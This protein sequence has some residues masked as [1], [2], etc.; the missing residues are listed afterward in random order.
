MQSDDNQVGKLALAMETAIL[1]ELATWEMI[2]LINGDRSSEVNRP[3]GQNVSLLYEM[4]E[5]ALWDT[6]K[7]NE[8]EAKLLEKIATGNAMV[9][10]VA[11]LDKE[12]IPKLTADLASD[13]SIQTPKYNN[14]WEHKSIRLCIEAIRDFNCDSDESPLAGTGEVHCRIADYLS[15][16]WLNGSSLEWLLLDA[17]IYTTLWDTLNKARDIDYDYCD[18]RYGQYLIERLAACS[19]SRYEPFLGANLSD[20]CADGARKQPSRIW[21]CFVVDE[22]SKSV[23][24]ICLPLAAAAG[25]Y[26]GGKYISA[27]VTDID[28]AVSIVKKASLML[29][30]GFLA[31]SG[32]FLTR[33]CR[34]II[35]YVSY[36]VFGRREPDDKIANGILLLADA[37]STLT[38]YVASPARLKATLEN[39]ERHGIKIDEAIYALIERAASRDGNI[40]LM[41]RTGSVNG[42]TIHSGSLGK[43][44]LSEMHEEAWKRFLTRKMTQEEFWECK[45]R[46]K[47]PPF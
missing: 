43:E 9:R 26:F 5:H 6:I 40:W 24:N 12:Y 33:L 42:R 38:G 37:Y 2:E 44:V 30:W 29:S 17:T 39:A 45:K 21:H 16:P 8:T 46:G 25:L 18:T 41:R 23:L 34:S 15:I 47:P 4:G 32:L 20:H 1:Y 10:L 36:S 28:N 27:S 22:L 7:N 19:Y 31:F 11:T 3:L 35:N 14:V 13:N